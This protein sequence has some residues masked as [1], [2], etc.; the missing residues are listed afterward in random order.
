[1]TPLYNEIKAAIRDR[2]DNEASTKSRLLTKYV[3]NSM[4]ALG[5]DIDGTIDEN[6]S[7]FAHLSHSYPGR[8]VIITYR[9]DKAKAINDVQ[10]YGVYF[11]D[12]FLVN[13]L[14]DKAR[15]IAEE[16]VKI[17]FDDQDECITNIPL[18]VTV[19]KMRNGGNFSNRK[20][21]YSEE[22]GRS[23]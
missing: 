3:C 13:S 4:P 20:W 21:L 15:V 9:K 12:I 8:V 7:F 17:Y 6:P 23:I 2:D 11:D 10:K 18:D 19:M 14:D 16:G 5:I 1:M 22:T